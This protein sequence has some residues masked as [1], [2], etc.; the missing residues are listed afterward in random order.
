MRLILI[1]CQYLDSELTKPDRIAAGIVHSTVAGLSTP[2]HIA[3]QIEHA[4]KLCGVT[5]FTATG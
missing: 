5:G 3:K 1:E 4:K 2:Q